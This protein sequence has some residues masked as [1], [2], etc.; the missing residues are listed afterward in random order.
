[1]AQK[2]PMEKSMGF[3][4]EYKNIYQVDVLQLLSIYRINIE[5]IKTAFSADCSKIFDGKN[6]GKIGPKYVP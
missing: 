6:M 3:E 2:I 4:R 1:M 5:Y